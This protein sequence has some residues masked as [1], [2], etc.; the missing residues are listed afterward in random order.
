LLD[1][2][3][4][5]ERVLGKASKTDK[6]L[7]E[8]KRAKLAELFEGIQSTHAEVMAELE[9]LRKDDAKVCSGSQDLFT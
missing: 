2:R 8:Q 4:I 3:A 6:V 9:L 5:L 1:E 7:K